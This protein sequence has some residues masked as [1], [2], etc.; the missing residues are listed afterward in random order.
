MPSTSMVARGKA[1]KCVLGALTHKLIRVAF[2][3]LK[4]Q[5]PFAPNLAKV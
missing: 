2:G 4:H 1:K 3:G 5:T